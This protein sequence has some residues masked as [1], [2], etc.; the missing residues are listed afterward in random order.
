M[1]LAQNQLIS[2]EICPENSHEISLFLPIVFR[3][4]EP[5]KFSMKVPQNPP[6]FLLFLICLWKSCEI[7]LFF[8]AT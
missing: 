6:I 4:S 7:W 3:Q 5:Q 2:S 1:K 8:P